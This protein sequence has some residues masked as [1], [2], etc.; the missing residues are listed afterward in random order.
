MGAITDAITNNPLSALGGLLGG[1]GLYKAY[2]DLGTLGRQGYNAGV[3]LGQDLLTETTFQ[4]YGITTGTG[5]QFNVDNLGQVRMTL[6]PE[7]QTMRQ[8]LLT[9]AQDLYARSQL[10]PS[11]RTTDIYND[12]LA[13]M[14]PG[15]IRQRQDL[16]ERMAAQGRLGI[17]SNAL[18][19]M[20]PEDFQLSFAQQEAMNNARLGAMQQ[21]RAEQAQEAALAQQMFGASYLPQAQLTAAL[22]PGLTAMGQRQQAQL[23]GAGL[24]GQARASGIDALLGAGLG[25]ANIVG[26]AATGLL[27]GL[28]G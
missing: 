6:T 14:E 8:N 13:A 10:D 23:Y 22:Q 28:V 4:P 19:G 1:L 26:S 15:M 24:M 18:G 5:G 16:E 12:M 7:E 20:A 3:S 27:S 11:A 21:A 17:R 9:G 25:R 2:S